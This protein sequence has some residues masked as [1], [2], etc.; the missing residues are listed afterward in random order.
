MFSGLLDDTVQLQCNLQIAESVA[1]RS[2]GSHIDCCSSWGLGDILLKLF[3]T[4]L[5]KITRQH[6]LKTSGGNSKN[7]QVTLAMFLAENSYLG[8][9]AC[10][11]CTQ[12]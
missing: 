5:L 1:M 8:Y 10:T 12:A 6:I 11:L 2:C 9:A 3:A 4:S 7:Y